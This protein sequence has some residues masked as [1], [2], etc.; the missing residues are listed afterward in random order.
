MNSTHRRDPRTTSTPSASCQPSCS[1]P[2][3]SPR[4]GSLRT[5]S[6]AS[7][8]ATAVVAGAAVTSV[9]ADVVTNIHINSTLYN[10]KIT[11]MPDIDQRRSSLPANG[12]MYCVPTA[13]FNIFAYAANHG[14][15]DVNPGPGN[16][17]ASNLYVT[18]NLWLVVLG[19]FMNTDAEDGTGGAGLQAGM[20]E[21]LESEGLLK[22]MYKWKSSNYTP[23][24]S[25]L[26]RFGCQGWAMSFCYGKWATIG[27]N[28]GIPIVDRVGGHAVT[29]TRAYR[30]GGTWI[31]RY[32]DPADDESLSTQSVFKNTERTPFSFTAWFGGVSVANLRTMTGIFTTSGGTRVID[33][34]FGIRPIYYLNFTNTGDTTGGGSIQ[35]I[36]PLGFEGSQ[37][38]NL[39]TI[40]ISPFLDVL[41]FAFDA[42]FENALVITKSNVI[43]TPS[44]LRSLD[45]TTG[46]LTTL[47]PSPENVERFA[48]DRFSRIYAF[49]TGNTL[50]AL[51]PEGNVVNSTEAIPTPTDI[52]VND[53][54]DSIWVLSVP[55][56]KLVKMTLDFSET[57]LTINVPT[58]V[59]MT[60]DGQIVIDPTTGFP[61]FRTDANDTLYGFIISSIAGP[62]LTS[63]SAPG[64]ADMDTFS[65]GDVGELFVA[66]DGSV[67]VFKKPV[68]AG[69]LL[70]PRH[71][72]HG[73]PGGTHMAMLR[74]SS[75]YDPTEH[76]GPDWNN[77]TKA[78][79]EENGPFVSDCPADLNGDEL[80]DGGDVGFLLSN[81]GGTGIADLNEDG[82]VDGGDLGLL[83]AA[84]GACI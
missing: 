35:M 67:K 33:T 79:L 34:L 28:S 7:W 58:P 69:W 71:P 36:D 84:W 59:P 61:W 78:Q 52:A 30:S 76:D 48:T 53:G 29:L 45:L 68:G 21:F 81:W 20:D 6:L 77:L 10:Y 42:D 47:A 80:I 38:A 83:L 54:D 4:T 73:L 11:H 27:T 46:V 2:S 43:V 25:R 75:N 16:W 44:R 5:G 74:N 56:R 66:G 14:Y 22:R 15:P 19:G 17:Q 39:P 55:Q 26:T 51:D 63:F 31:L 40:N 57:L 8:L 37:N 1:L 3:H 49:D 60:G 41:D 72:F 12:S 82:T 9:T 32:R 65:I 62:Q 13:T 24:L 70:D 18:T 23:T 50:W 64:L